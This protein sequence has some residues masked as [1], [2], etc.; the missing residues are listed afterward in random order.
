LRYWLEGD[1]ERPPVLR[2]EPRGDNTVSWG[3]FVEAGL[4]RTY[5]MKDVS[6][7]HLR[8]VIERLRD[9]FGTPYP[10][11][12]YTPFITANRKLVLTAQEAAGMPAEDGLVW[13]IA[14]GQTVL[15]DSV[16]PVS[17]VGGL[18]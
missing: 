5:R 15:R 7:Q 14:S 12:T 18:R 8:S 10:L 1:A 6:L 17:R 3:E 2:Q 13:E 9:D 4:L 16:V 11:A